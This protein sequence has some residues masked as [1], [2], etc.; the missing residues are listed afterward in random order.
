[1]AAHPGVDRGV[2]RQHGGYVFAPDQF[3]KGFGGF[4]IER[5]PGEFDELVLEGGPEFDADAH[6][7]A[8][9]A[10]GPQQFASGLRVHRVVIDHGKKTD[11]LDPGVHNQ[12]RRAFAALG[13]GV[14]HMVVKSVLVPGFGHFQQMVAPQQGTHDARGA[15]TAR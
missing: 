6:R 12:V 10:R 4:R 3:R 13:V 2:G 9:D 7:D 8:H 5:R 11:A 15:S 1:M 14:V